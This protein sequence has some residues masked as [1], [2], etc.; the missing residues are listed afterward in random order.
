[1]T[2][3]AERRTINLQTAP[4]AATVISGA[5]LQGGGH[6]DRSTT[7]SSTR[8][9]LTVADFGQG[10]AL[11][12][13]RHRQGPDQRPDALRRGHLLGRRRRRIPGFFADAP[14]YDISNIEVLR[15]PQG[16]FAGQNAT[17]GAVFITTNDPQLG[18]SAAT[19]RGSTA[20]TTTC[21][22]HGF[23]NMPIGDDAGRARRLQRRAARQLLH[24]GRPLD[25]A[26][27]AASRAACWTASLRVGVPLAAD[28]R[29][30]GSTFKADVDY[31]DNGGFLGRHDAGSRQP[32]AAQ[33]RRPLPYQVVHQRTTAPTRAT[34]CRERRLHL[35]RRHRAEV[36]HR[37]PV[38]RG[39]GNIDLAEL[40]RRSARSRTTAARRSSRRSSTSS[41]RTTGPAALGRRPL[42]PARLCDVAAGRRHS[43]A[44]T[45]TSWWR[46]RASSSR[47]W[48]SS[49][50]RRRPPRPC[51]ARSAT[52]SR[53]R[54]SCR[55]RLRYTNET[56][57]LTDNSPTLLTVFGTTT[58]ISNAAFVAHT[59]DS[60]RHRQGRAELEAG[61]QQLPLRL[62]RHRPEGRRHQHH[63]GGHADRSRCRSGR[64]R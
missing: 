27:A 15:G 1:M 9:S 55:W 35:Q 18:R 56:F 30:C 47:I 60:G 16:T 21:W 59:S 28:R 37:L 49:T 45:S 10:N 6:H 48:T 29:S 8:P 19:S 57:G 41:R 40:G 64:R 44:S 62:R 3:T 26:F 7:C 17:G 52:T 50:A 32:E 5:Q 42:L 54:C 11:Q 22:L 33:S 20:T 14:Y 46:P 34:A 58:L 25:D 53:R 63:A 24:G 4:L 61:R 38:R 12:H 51:S 43:R 36:D 23:V 2:I 31:V 13:P 39:N